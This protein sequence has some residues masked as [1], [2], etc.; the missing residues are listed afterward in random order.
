MKPLVAMMMLLAQ[1]FTAQA[2]QP[3]RC[4]D[5]C[6]Q[7]GHVWSHCA[8]QCEH[9]NAKAGR[10]DATRDD[11]RYQERYDG[12]YDQRDNA[13][14]DE[15]QGRG[16]PAP[17]LLPAPRVPPVP[18]GQP[19]VPL[20]DQPGLPRNPAFDAIERDAQPPARRQQALPAN[21]D[22]KCLTDCQ[23]NGYEFG[24]CLRQCSY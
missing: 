18:P 17:G 9:D 12:R 11:G 21:T 20:L 24:L 14:Y 22:R 3:S 5:L 16:K 4:Q 2:T 7:Q 8:Q 10:H 6:L 15:R 13:R 19:V 1:V 23:R